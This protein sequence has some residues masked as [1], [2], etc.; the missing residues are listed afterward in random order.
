[1]EVRADSPVTLNCSAEGNPDPR[2]TWSFKT[3]DGW[4]IRKSAAGQLFIPMAG[5][6]EDG[7]YRCEAR[8]K[9]GSSS[10]TVVVKVFGKFSKLVQLNDFIK[11]INKTE[12]NKL[13]HSRAIAPTSL[14]Q[15]N[16]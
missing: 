8:N 3:K 16:S 9:E 1:M 2:I 7:Q 14:I 15:N 6:S 12:Y 11:K 5:L 13:D 4:S 10:A